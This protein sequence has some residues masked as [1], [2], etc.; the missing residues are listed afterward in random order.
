MEKQWWQEGRELTGGMGNLWGRGELG[1]V[2][3]CPWAFTSLRWLLET[4][5][6]RGLSRGDPRV[7]PQ[8]WGAVGFHGVGS[9]CWPF[10]GT[11]SQPLAWGDS[12]LSL[13]S[14]PSHYCSLGLQFPRVFSLPL[15]FSPPLSHRPRGVP[16]PAPPAPAPSP[17]SGEEK[18]P[19]SRYANGK[20]PARRE[21]RPSQPREMPAH[22]RKVENPRVPAA[23][24]SAERGEP[25][26][27]TPRRPR[28]HQPE[29][30]LILCDSRD[31]NSSSGQK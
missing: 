28:R 15:V 9:V 27:H 11:A 7:E 4:G 24:G 20:T 12:A 19:C 30:S 18:G 21:L 10:P 3:C 14:L 31:S 2:F 1:S 6:H 5:W 26:A 23:R 17:P 29:L 16:A 13:P 22:G 25:P 8:P